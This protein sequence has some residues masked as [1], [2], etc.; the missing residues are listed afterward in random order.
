MFLFLHPFGIELLKDIQ[1]IITKLNEEWIPKQAQ[2]WDAI[3]ESG[4]V[5]AAKLGNKFTPLSKEEEA[6]W[7]QAVKPLLDGYVTNAT[8]KGVPGDQA[9]KFCQDYLKKYNK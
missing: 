5:Y 3:D 9:L 4:K 2:T 7:A 1:Q 8:A 6:R